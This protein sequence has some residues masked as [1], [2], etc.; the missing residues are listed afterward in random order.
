MAARR[1][2]HVETAI[3]A[4]LAQLKG[5]AAKAGAL[6]SDDLGG[7]LLTVE[8]VRR[9]KRQLHTLSHLTFR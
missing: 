6:A 7:D 8:E 5:L 4:A 3:P 2:L 9:W 1:R